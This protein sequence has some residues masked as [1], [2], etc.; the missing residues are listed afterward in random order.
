MANPVKAA[1]KE[2][3]KMVKG[4]RDTV[5]MQKQTAKAENILAKR[6]EKAEKISAKASSSKASSKPSESV[7]K[8]QSKSAPSMSSGNKPE[9]QKSKSSLPAAPTKSKSAPKGSAKS[10]SKSTSKSTGKYGPYK[11]GYRGATKPASKPTAKPATKKGLA[12]GVADPNK[13]IGDYTVNEVV[14]GVKNTAK[15]AAAEAITMPQRVSKDLVNRAGRQLKRM[16]NATTFGAFEDQLKKKGGSAK[17][18][19]KKGGYMMNVKKKKK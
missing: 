14:E 6:K 11:D 5:K 12:D 9:L 16:V 3:R 1:R 2:G 15:T 13:K 10:G 7:S 18:S 19:Y 17:P 8:I 4:A